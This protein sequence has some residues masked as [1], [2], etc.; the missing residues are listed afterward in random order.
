MVTL[1]VLRYQVGW[2]I[3]ECAEATRVSPSTL[4]R[5]EASERAG[6]SHPVQGRIAW[7]ITTAFSEKLGRDIAVEDIA[8]MHIQAPKP[9]RPK[10]SG[11]EI[12]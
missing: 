1:Q 6:V 12:R 5:I 7:R 4:Q 10:R 9:G 11:T 8:G 2:G 3:R